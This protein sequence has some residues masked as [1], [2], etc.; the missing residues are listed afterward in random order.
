M[1]VLLAIGLMIGGLWALLEE[2]WYSDELVR[3]MGSGPHSAPWRDDTALAAK[4]LPHGMSRGAATTYLARN[5]FS[6]TGN[7]QLECERRK[8]GFACSA[9]YTVHLSLNDADM[10]AGLKA[11]SYMACL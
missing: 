9:T 3:Q 7:T 10:V 6:C 11:N 8:P 2:P 1:S 5:G 4:F